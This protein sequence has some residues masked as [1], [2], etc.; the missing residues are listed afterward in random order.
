[1]ETLGPPDIHFLSAAVGW[2][3][4]GN[5][6]EARAELSRIDPALAHHPG[7]LET[8]WG[9]SAAEQ[10]WPKALTVAQQLVDQNPDRPS[11]WLHRAYALRRTPDGGLQAAWEALL[12]AVQRFPEEA[13][14]PYN[15]ACYACQLGQLDESRRWLRQALKVGDHSKIK[16]MAI[17]DSDLELLW[18]EIKAWK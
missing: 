11:G 10:N 8:A 14:I 6:D 3:E 5:Y 4:L 2:M 18:K 16:A 7:V 17:A 15:L 12:P 13:T 1:M 9:I